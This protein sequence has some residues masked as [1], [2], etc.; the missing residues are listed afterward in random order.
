[1]AGIGEHRFL[2]VGIQAPE[3]LLKVWAASMM[4][5]VHVPTVSAAAPPVSDPRP[6]D[7]LYIARL[8]LFQDPPFLGHVP[9]CGME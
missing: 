7:H 1:M 6:H 2:V 9:S 4:L 8:S 3:L 5:F